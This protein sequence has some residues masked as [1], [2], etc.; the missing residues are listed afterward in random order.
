MFCELKMSQIPLGYTQIFLSVVEQPLRFIL[1][2]TSVAA[3]YAFS[4]TAILHSFSLFIA[5][6][7]ST[8]FSVNIFVCFLYRGI[9]AKL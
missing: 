2:F 1:V 9:A 8:A 7:S 3:S 6:L 5:N 4:C